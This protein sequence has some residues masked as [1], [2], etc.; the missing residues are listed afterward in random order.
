[1]HNKDN[2]SRW[3]MFRR[4]DNYSV[5]QILDDIEIV[6]ACFKEYTISTFNIWDV[7]V[8]IKID[9]II[10]SLKKKEKNNMILALDTRID[11]LLYYREYLSERI[12]KP[13]PKHDDSA[14]IYKYRNK[15]NETMAC[16]EERYADKPASSI[17]EIASENQ[18]LQI[19][20]MSKWTQLLYGKS[21]REYLLEE[22]IITKPKKEHSI[23]DDEAVAY[24]SKTDA[25][26]FQKYRNK[27]VYTLTQLIDEN[28]S[29]N[30]NYFGELTKWQYDETAKEHLIR[31]GLISKPSNNG[32]SN[33]DKVIDILNSLISKYSNNPAASMNQIVRENPDFSLYEFNRLSESVYG[34]SGKSLLIKWR[35]IDQNHKTNASKKT[36]KS[37]LEIAESSSL[38]STKDATDKKP[39]ILLE[40][41][42]DIKQDSPISFGD[43][44]HK[45]YS[46]NISLVESYF[47]K[48]DEK[49][50]GSSFATKSIMSVDSY[51]DLKPYLTV[52]EQIVFDMNGYNDARE[53]TSQFT[54]HLLARYH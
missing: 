13:E 46:G 14:L 47:K 33:L 29:I 39:N 37:Q 42:S 21:A 7:E 12:R 10:H 28:D 3:L 48:V 2:F 23:N 18:D 22:H 36:N 25:F 38:A 51:N 52:I 5:S 11:S 32:K 17:A 35:V 20:D 9:A 8:P 1:M 40:K 19:K 53:A 54:E 43:W 50:S 31:I 4:E 27:P 44:L 41:S 24:I 26:L 45:H 15:L 16:L 30:F 34:K 49:L 6:G